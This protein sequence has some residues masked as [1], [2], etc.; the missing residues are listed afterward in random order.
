MSM[1]LRL[2]ANLAD[3]AKLEDEYVQFIRDTC[4]YAHA[5]K[6]DSGEITYLVLGVAGEAGEFVDEI[7]KIVRETGF[8][9]REYFQRVLH[10]P[11]HF[12]KIMK[13]L[14]DLGWYITRILDLMGVSKKE[15]MVRNTYKL[16][17]RLLSRNVDFPDL[18]W[19]FTDPFM[20]YDNVKELID[21]EDDHEGSF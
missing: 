17:N 4:W 12:E 6:N 8:M 7:K 14:G 3:N 18:K 16:Y 11:E 19:P 21:G 2:Q 15:L 5:G 20:T 1:N 9:D 13:E 10:D